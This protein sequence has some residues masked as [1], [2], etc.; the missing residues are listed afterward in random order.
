[1]FVDE[2]ILCEDDLDINEYVTMFIGVVYWH[3][4]RL[5]TDDE[6]AFLSITKSFT[7]L[8]E[9]YRTMSEIRYADLINEKN[10]MQH[11]IRKSMYPMYDM[12]G[13]DLEE[14]CSNILAG[15]ESKFRSLFW[16]FYDDLENGRND[17]WKWRFIT[18]GWFHNE[19]KGFL[20]TVKWGMDSCGMEAFLTDSVLWDRK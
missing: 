2:F 20:K 8:F 10:A 12:Y 1:M 11:V 16:N 18:P 17:L 7:C 13:K 19:K 9:G 3:H 6:Y 15:D 4:N 5:E 14:G